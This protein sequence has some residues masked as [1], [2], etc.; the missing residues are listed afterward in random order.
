MKIIFELFSQIYPI[1]EIYVK[2]D[3]YATPNKN[4]NEK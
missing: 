3:P 1:L 4:P 2:C